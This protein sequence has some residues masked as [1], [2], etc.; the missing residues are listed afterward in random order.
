FRR[1]ALVRGA[2]ETC[3]PRATLKIY[4]GRFDPLASIYRPSCESRVR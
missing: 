2:G 3:C 1:I 4:G